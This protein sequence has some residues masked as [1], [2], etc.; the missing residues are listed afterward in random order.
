MLRYLA[1]V[2][3]R[4]G[5][6]GTGKVRKLWEDLEVAGTGAERVPYLLYPVGGKVVLF[7]YMKASLTALESCRV[8]LAV[9][10][11]VGSRKL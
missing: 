8:S 6:L 11:R 7:S 10:G 3:R 4:D 1:A 2:H 5:T 9:Q